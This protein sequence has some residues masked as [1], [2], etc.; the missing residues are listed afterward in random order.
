MRVYFRV[1]ASSKIGSGHVI[2]CLTLARNLKA[3]GVNCVFVCR[4]Y[5]DNLIKR[6][7]YEGFKVFKILKNNSYKNIKYRK[8]TSK[9]NSRDI[10]FTWEDDANLQ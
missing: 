6:I 9:K 5:K 10:D 3:S 7:N 2:R 1:D 8:N 4:N